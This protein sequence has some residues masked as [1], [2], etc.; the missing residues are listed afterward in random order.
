ML[1]EEDGGGD[2]GNWRWALRRA[3]RCLA[4]RLRRL[5]NRR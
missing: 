1:V 2:Y 3:R 5:R 4:F